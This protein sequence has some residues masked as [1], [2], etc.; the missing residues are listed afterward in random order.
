MV[1]GRGQGTAQ[2]ANPHS[3]A[4]R[5]WTSDPQHRAYLDPRA[6]WSVSSVA[7]TPSAGG[8]TTDGLVGRSSS[9]QGCSATRD[10]RHTRSARRDM[11]HP[12]GAEEREGQRRLRRVDGSRREPVSDKIVTRCTAMRCASARD[13]TP[14][15]AD[16]VDERSRASPPETCTFGHGVHGPALCRPCVHARDAHQ[17]SSALTEPARHDRR[18]LGPC[19]GRQTFGRRGATV[20]A[21]A[22][23]EAVRL[24]PPWSPP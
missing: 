14:G 20:G 6:C 15:L 24:E 12:C 5:V 17:R 19:A 13:A 21:L 2:D 9:G 18:Q 22:K 16:E 11:T 10:R 8:M 3:H 4:G 23:A 7:T 1:V